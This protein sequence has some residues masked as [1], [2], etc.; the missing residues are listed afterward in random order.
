MIQSAHIGVGIMG[1]EGNQAAQ[2]SDYAIP[3]FQGLN[4][5]VFWH[6]RQFGTKAVTFLIPLNLFKGFIFTGPVFF[7][8]FD[9]G[10]SGLAIFNDFYYSLFNVWLTT[11]SCA[12]F[13]WTD[14]DVSYNFGKYKKD[15]T[16]KVPH[17]AK[18]YSPIVAQQL[19]MDSLFSQ[20]QW[21]KKNGIS[22]NADGSTNNHTD[23]YAWCR[24]FWVGSLYHQFWIYIGWAILVSSMMY[25]LSYYSLC[26][27]FNESGMVLDFLNTGV[28]PFYVNIVSHHVY[29][30]AETRNHTWFSSAWY[31]LSISLFILTIY[32]NDVF[33]PS[34]YFGL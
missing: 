20:D 30:L 4:R 28:I 8:Q 13:V 9:N 5:L 3:N 1:K 6:G 2:F 12:T 11:F 32:F 16:Q 22:Q 34:M 15:S 23:Y 14:Q 17:T 26:F 7:A 19:T 21:M 33:A 27:A 18:E 29:C 31:T 24:D 25:Y 10:F